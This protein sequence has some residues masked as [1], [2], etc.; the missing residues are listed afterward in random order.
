M[1]GRYYIE[2]T[3][4][5]DEMHRIIET[6]NRCSE[7]DQL[8]TSGEIFPTD[9]VPVVATSRG[10][11]ASAFAMSWGYTLTDGK[12]VIN[13][14][15]ESAESKSLFRDGMLQRRCA[16]PASHYF[17]W[18]RSK[19]QKSKFAIQPTGGDMMY[20]AGI[21]R[22]EKEMP[23]FAILTREP[24]DNIAFLHDRMPVILPS[25]AVSDWINPRYNANDLLKTAILDVQYRKVE[26]S[27]CEQ[28]GM[29]L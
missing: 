29:E 14:R 25:E 23:V 7:T 10:M 4:D 12:K 8:K 11:R 16:I 19:K 1:C 20:L 2:E 18:E 28:I 13:A 3:T 15:S 27:A 21:Y 24:A 26:N 17:E 5:S 6:V 22:M 9:V